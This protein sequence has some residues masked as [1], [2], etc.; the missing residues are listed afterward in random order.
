[1][2]EVRI[3]YR[4]PPDRVEVFRQ[5]VLHDA[6]AWVATLLPAAAVRR[7]LEI[8]GRVV[9]EPGAPIVW[10]TYRGDVWHDVGRFHLADGTFTGLYANVLTPV[11]MEGA[12]WDTTDLYLDVWRGADGGTR[13]LDEEEFGAACAAGRVDARDAA[14]ARREAER[15]L[16]DER[17]GRWPPPH[18]LE[19]TLERALAILAAGSPPEPANPSDPCAS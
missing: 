4:R 2:S 5:A 12:R 11:R 19:W 9:L 3:H 17:T 1:V 8:G 13:L 15:L 10:F 6:G 14:R 7:P 18:V 16:A